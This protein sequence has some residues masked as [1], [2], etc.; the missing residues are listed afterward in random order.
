MFPFK[1]A[2]VKGGIS[3]GK[4][5][6]IDVDDLSPR[7]K[8]TR[9]SSGVYDP[10]KFKSYV[11]FQTHENYFKDATPLVEKVVDQPSLIDTTILKWFATKDWNYLLS[12][13]DDAYENL[14]KEFYANA[15]VEGEGLKCWVRGKSFSVRFFI[16]PQSVSPHFL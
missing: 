5:S 4:E 3:K 10:N 14:V 7:S 2:T 11:A 16:I 6:V 9:S 12:N 13:L 15:I 1:R 8:R